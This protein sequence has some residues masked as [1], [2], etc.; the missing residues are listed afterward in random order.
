MNEDMLSIG[1]QL[2]EAREVKGWTVEEAARRTKLKA[3]AIRKMEADEFELFPSISYARG[4]IRIYARELG[5]NGWEL[6]RNFEDA[7]DVAVDGLDLHPDDLESIPRRSQPP[8]ATSQGI[9]LFVV[10]VVFLVVLLL[11]GIKVYQIWGGDG[12]SEDPAI[13]QSIEAAELAMVQQAGASDQPAP[14]IVKAVPDENSID[15]PAAVAPA[16]TLAVPAAPVAQP[17][18]GAA[19]VP[20]PEVMAE[21]NPAEINRL[22][23][24]AP[25]NAPDE[26]RWVR[27][28]AIN[29]GQESILY[30][31]LIP[32]GAT[33]PDPLSPAWSAGEFRIKFRQAAAIQIIFNETN[34]GSYER[35]GVQTVNLP[36]R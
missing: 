24:R 33:L 25:V 5:L 9:G 27:V 23:L 36:I 26:D 31:A 32:A 35:R 1:A 3:D 34:Y 17:V 29:N 14:V 12:S 21:P 16:E 20:T 15:A 11:A 4:F 28:V 7:P 10:M 6:M 2:T 19:P 22:R 13:A 18:E 8:L 30:E